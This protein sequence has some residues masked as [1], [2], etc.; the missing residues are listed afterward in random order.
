MQARIRQTII[1]N[2][3]QRREEREKGEVGN[4]GGLRGGST[5]VNGVVYCVAGAPRFRCINPR[6]SAWA[7]VSPR[8]DGRAVIITE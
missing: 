1:M 4:H 5:L 2:C 6:V 7:P 3:L 8:S